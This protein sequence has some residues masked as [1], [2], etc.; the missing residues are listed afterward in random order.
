MNSRKSA[1]PELKKLSRRP[2]ASRPK[3]VKAVKAKKTEKPTRAN[4]AMNMT[5]LQFMARSRG[6]P[7]GGLSKAK[8]IKKINNYY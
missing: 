2:R 8:L 5:E 3:S 4:S 1:K 6:I 7:F